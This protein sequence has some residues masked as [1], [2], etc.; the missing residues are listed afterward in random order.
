MLTAHY[1]E[2]AMRIAPTPPS[3]HILQPLY[4]YN[5]FESCHPQYIFIGIAFLSLLAK[6]NG[7]CCEKWFFYSV[8]FLEVQELTPSVWNNTV[9]IYSTF[10]S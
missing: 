1:E 9:I 5:A 7:R 4:L 2:M 3:L 8:G 10:I 6:T